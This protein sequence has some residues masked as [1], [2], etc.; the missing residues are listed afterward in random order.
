MLH[1]S[2]SRDDRLCSWMLAAN[3]GS[4]EQIE[5]VEKSAQVSGLASVLVLASVLALVLVLVS[6][7]ALVLALVL[8]LLHELVSVLGVALQ[9]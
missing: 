2:G 9:Q 3:Q 8:A 7:L 1:F 6:A 4:Q 5:R